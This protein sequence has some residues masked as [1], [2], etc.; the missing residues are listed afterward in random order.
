MYKNGASVEMLPNFAAPDRLWI[1]KFL[2]SVLIGIFPNFI[3][4]IIMSDIA[5]KEN[6]NGTRSFSINNMNP[7]LIDN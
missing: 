4:E 5:T 2:L 6:D 7:I 3:F 1:G